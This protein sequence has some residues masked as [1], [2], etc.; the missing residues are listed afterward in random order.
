MKMRGMLGG[1]KLEIMPKVRH[2]SFRV[3]SVFTDV[4]IF[5]ASG[6]DYV[7]SSSYVPWHA[8][9]PVSRITC[10]CDLRKP[11]VSP[12]HRRPVNLS[13]ITRSIEFSLGQY[14]TYLTRVTSWSKFCNYVKNF[15]CPANNTFI[16][17][18]SCSVIYVY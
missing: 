17:N 15:I 1:T 7:K 18:Y 8:I 4:M 2:P 14:F 9:E 5:R 16:K 10:N 12:S 3:M 13:K 6:H 11:T